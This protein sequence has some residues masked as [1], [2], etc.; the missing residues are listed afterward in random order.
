[1]ATWVDL[2]AELQLWK[3]A[4]CS[5]TFWW[6][7]D[8]T[9]APTDDLDRLIGLAERYAAPLHL[10]VIPVGIN[11]ALAS[12]LSASPLVYALQHGFAHVNHEPKGT[13]ASE[14]GDLRDVTL[15]I[16]DLRAGWQKLAMAELPNL[17]PVLVPPWN[18]VAQKTLPH[19]PALGFRMLSAFDGGASAADVAGLQQI[20]AHVDPVRWKN[21]AEF[22]G[23]EKTL[24]QV[25]EHLCARRL[26][27]ANEPTGFLTHHLQTDAA[28]WDFIDALLDRL[29]GFEWICLSSVIETP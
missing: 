2:D 6:R 28:T 15:Q 8:D 22:R 26:G 9:Q 16:A 17:L 20:N 4:G 12:R 11:P 29:Q 25:V 19:L 24:A 13:R 21:G 7:D 1:M 14:I 27:Q 3:D 5:P 10:A 18:R 23:T